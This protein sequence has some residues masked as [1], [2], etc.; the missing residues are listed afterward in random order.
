[1]N[2]TTLLTSFC[3]SVE[4]GD[5][6]AFAALFTPDGVYH[7]VFYGTFSGRDR[8]AAMLTDWFHRDARDF[9]W[10]MH[11]PVCDGTTLYARYV[12]SFTSKLDGAEGRRA[13]FEGVSIM[14]L[15]DGQIAAYQEVANP[16]PGLLDLGFPAERVAKI[17]GREGAALKARPES[18]RHLTP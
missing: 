9:R 8:I 18:T 13:M 1:M 4:A 6:A 14:T 3:R 16:G 2:P 17:L 7:D 10:D 12:F 15:R 11:E 5:G